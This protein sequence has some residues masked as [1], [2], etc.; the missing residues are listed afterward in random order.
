MGI[1]FDEWQNY[2]KYGIKYLG[3][4]NTAE[5]ESFFKKSLQEAEKYGNLVFIAF[6]LR[7][8]ST[9]QVKNRKF[10]LA[11]KGFRK[12]LIYCEKLENRKGI[13]EATA[14]LGSVYYCLELYDQ[15]EKWYERAI[16]AYPEDASRIRLAMLYT[17]LGNVY[18]KTRRW[19]KAELLFQRACQICER[20]SFSKGQ[21]ELMLLLGEV[22]YGQGECS[23]AKKYFSEA[24]RIFAVIED[25]YFLANA[26]QHLAFILL[27]E[28]RYHEALLYLNRAICIYAKQEASGELSESYYL[29]ANIC[30]NLKLLDEAEASVFTSMKFYRGDD[31]GYAIR[32]QMIAIISILKKK[33]E[34]AKEHYSEALRYYQ[35][36]GDSLKIGEICEELTYLLKYENLFQENFVDL[37]SLRSQNAKLPKHKLMFYFALAMEGTG[38][39]MNA[40]KFGW[41]ALELAKL[42]EDET[43]EI[44]TFI[45]ELSQKIRRNK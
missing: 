15:A 39:N 3:E 24:A 23:K 32:F 37:L 30:Q 20:S 35:R 36:F 28:G 5:A 17:D 40:L 26:L 44:E 21:G 34:K 13:S 11:E 16:E 31:L 25:W 9:A 38:K 7:L 42:L 8:L 6:S 29:L 33:Y 1:N 45:Q 4:G 2:I 18:S 19:E 43:E 12:A 10:E 14:G 22:Y 27:E 41:K